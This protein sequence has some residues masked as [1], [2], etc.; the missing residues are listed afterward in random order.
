[1]CSSDLPLTQADGDEPALGVR[2]TDNHSG[3]PPGIS[4]DRLALEPLRLRSRDE[5]HPLASASRL[6]SESRSTLSTSPTV[7]R[8][9]AVNSG[10]QQVVSRLSVA[11]SRLPVAAPAAPPAQKCELDPAPEKPPPP[12]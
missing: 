9:T 8:F 6:S 11:V 5:P 2:H 3:E 1:M 4:A 12:E 7:K 10:C